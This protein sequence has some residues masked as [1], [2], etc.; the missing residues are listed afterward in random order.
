M[1]CA[2]GLL[3]SKTFMNN[4]KPRS[5][6]I[7]YSDIVVLVTGTLLIATILGFLTGFLPYP[8]GV[9]VLSIVFVARILFLLKQKKD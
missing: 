7:L 3:D 6:H 5:R 4:K 8:V 9:I 1:P 2:T